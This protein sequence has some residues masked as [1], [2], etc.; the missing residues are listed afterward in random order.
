MGLSLY[1]PGL[2]AT[3]PPDLDWSGNSE[4]ERPIIHRTLPIVPALIEELGEWQYPGIEASLEHP[5]PLVVACHYAKTWRAEIN[6]S[7]PLTYVADET[8]S[9]SGA[10]EWGDAMN[11]AQQAS[12][13]GI[14][15]PD[16]D[17]NAIVVSIQIGS[18]LGRYEWGGEGKWWP[19]ITIFIQGL[20]TG[21]NVAQIGNALDFPERGGVAPITF[22]IAG[23]TVDLYHRSD[24]TG[25]PVTGSITLTAQEWLAA[26]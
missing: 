18:S 13:Y 26:Y 17:F 8:F 15:G 6:L 12:F 25:T 3:A 7:G 16:D 11:H 24:N 22:T 20:G 5:P 14:Q 21:S 10:G 4:V 19:P 1:I 23:E 2:V 9:V